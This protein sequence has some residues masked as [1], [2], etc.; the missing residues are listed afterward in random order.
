MFGKSGFNNNGNGG[1]AGGDKFLM[2]KVIGALVVFTGALIFA[3]IQFTGESD[4]VSTGGSFVSGEAF[5]QHGE[6]T[7]PEKKP[8]IRAPST[9]M[10]KR[11]SIDLFEKTNES[12]FEAQ[13]KEA[14][15][16]EAERK[17][18]LTGKKN[19]KQPEETE[20]Q[21][22]A[23]K[24]TRKKRQETVIPRMQLSGGNGGSGEQSAAQGQMPAGMPD[25]SKLQGANGQVDQEQLQKLMQ[26]AGKGQ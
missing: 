14:E 23:G 11:D 22:T 17:A 24:K 13:R 7:S 3:I 2:V 19:V 26:N 15:A 12:Y 1:S 21:Q 20:P 6:S 9:K 16:Q 8:M 10:N 25:L 4:T 5:R 18:R